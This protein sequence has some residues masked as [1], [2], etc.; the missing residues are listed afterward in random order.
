[1]GSV[2]EMRERGARLDEACAAIGRDPKAIVRSLL[3]VPAIMPDEH[4]WDSVEAFAD[5]T[6]RF[7]GAGVDEFILQ[8]P[9]DG[10]WAIVERIAYEVIPALRR[11]AQNRV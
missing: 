1:M 8:P 4:P 11:G 9:L 2:E 10:N 6:G 3:H 5:Y 7:A